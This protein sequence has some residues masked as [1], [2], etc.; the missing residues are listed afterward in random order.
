MTAAIVTGGASGVGRSTVE[1]LV[2]RGVPVVAVDRR[3]PDDSA[4]DDVVRITGDV[5]DAGTWKEAVDAAQERGGLSKL[6]INAA[7]LAVGSV[8]DVADDELRQVFEVNVFAAALALRSCLPVMIDQGGGAVVGVAST[9]AVFAE[10]GLAA[11]CASKGALLQ[12]MRCVAVDHARQGIR[13]NVVCPGAIDTPFFRQHVDA[14][15]DPEAFL[16]VKTE[17]HPSGRILQPEDVAEVVA[18]L[19]SDAAIGMNGT[20]V[21][22]DGGLTTTFDFKDA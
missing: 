17:R 7:R 16:R 15:P 13:A 20:P 10:Q 6:V 5:C 11:Y 21:M 14:A 8:L 12:L 3:W 9:D 22:I 19:L 2:G 18:F 4:A 1:I